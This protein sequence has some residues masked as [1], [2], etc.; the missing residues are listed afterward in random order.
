MKRNPPGAPL[1]NLDKEN[2]GA[3]VYIAHAQAKRFSKTEARAVK[4]EQQC[5][6]ERRPKPRALKSGAK[7]QQFQNVLFGKKIRNEGGLGGQ[8]RPERFHNFPVGLSAQIAKELPQNR[9]IAGYAHGLALRFARQ[10]RNRCPVELPAPILGGIVRQEPVAL[11]Q[12]K[13][14]PGI[15]IPQAPLELEETVQ[16]AGNRAVEDFIHR[17]TGS[18]TPRRRLNAT[19]RRRKSITFTS[20]L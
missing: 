13:L 15:S 7:F 19:L 20:T 3:G 4:D 9:S 1:E 18:A 6:I 14:R 5:A 11:A 17:G 2:A 10:P 16:V 12:R 8:L